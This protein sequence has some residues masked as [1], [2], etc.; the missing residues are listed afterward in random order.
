MEIA[1]VDFKEKML[2][3]LKEKPFCQ[4]LNKKTMSFWLSDDGKGIMNSRYGALLCTFEELYS[5]YEKAIELGGEMYLGAAAAQAGKRIGSE[6]F[7]LE[8]MDAF[9]ATEFYGKK[10][11]DTVTRRSTYYAYILD[12]AGFAYNRR[13]GIMLINP[14]YM[15]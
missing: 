1:F 7:P 5:I 4:M 13:G 10:E 8:T 6:D 14:V 3:K 15:A 12:W 2:Q 11:G 9:I